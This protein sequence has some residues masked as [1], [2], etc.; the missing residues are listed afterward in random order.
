MIYEDEN[1]TREKLLELRKGNMPKIGEIRKGSEIGYKS[2]SQKFVWHACVKC[3]RQRWVTVVR[4]KPHRLTCQFCAKKGTHLDGHAKHWKG[5]RYKS[6]GY[7]KV[8]IAPNDFFASMRGKGGYAMEHRIIMAKHLGRV[9]HLWETV[10]HKNHI[11]DDNRIENLQLVS[12]ERHEQITRLEKRIKFLEAKV[13]EQGKLIK[14][15]QWELKEKHY[16]SNL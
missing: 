6:E 16:A 9:L 10:H 4:G 14:F 12:D 15:L 2:R 8:W 3:G 13:E 5:G 1:N 11:R 7:I